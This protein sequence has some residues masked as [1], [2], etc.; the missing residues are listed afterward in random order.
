MQN[1]EVLRLPWEIQTA[2]ASGYA[3]YM[4][5]Y[6]GIRMRHGALDAAFLTLVFSLI[7]TLALTA[8]A[9]FGPLLSAPSAFVTTCLT[10]FVWRRWVRDYYRAAIRYF[11]VSWSDDDQS[12]LD[13]LLGNSSHRISQIAV[14]LDDGTW[15]RCDDAAKF[16]DSPFGPCV[17]GPTGDVA[18]YLTHEERLGSE[19]RAL[20]SVL[21]ADYG[22]R[23]TYI[24]AGRIK[25]VTLR[26]VAR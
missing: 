25:R 16:K 5:A 7:A 20:T 19:A 26:H 11:D 9:R 17:L 12:A 10:G 24:P 2:L 1:L 15:L 13:T 3:A 6:T 4:L 18:L 14:L 21:S 22:D 23:I 8:T